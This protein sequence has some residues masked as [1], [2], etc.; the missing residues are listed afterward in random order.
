VPLHIVPA[1]VSADSVGS[2]IPGMS[3]ST[4]NDIYK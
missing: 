3:T 4:A 1:E 2:P